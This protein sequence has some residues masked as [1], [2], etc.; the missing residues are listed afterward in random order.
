MAGGTTLS[1]VCGKTEVMDG[2]AP[3]GLG[4]TYAGNP[5]AIAASHAVMDVMEE[6]KLV[7]R[8]NILGAK[9]TQRLK[10][11]QAKIPALKDVR[12]LGSMIAAE[13]FD[14]K[15]QMPSSEITKHVQQAALAKGLILLTCGVYTNALRFLYPLTIEDAVFDE[16]LA[17]LEGALLSANT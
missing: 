11:L 6:E 16:A 5:L 14:P 4:G 10:T 12:G 15:T 7:E 13:F 3:G 17:I 2:P 8:A 9:L 1:A